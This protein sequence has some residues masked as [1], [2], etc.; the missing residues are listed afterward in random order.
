MIV[1]GRREWVNL[2]DLDLDNE[3]F[4]EIAGNVRVRRAAQAT[5]LLMPQ[6]ALVDYAV[7][8]MEENHRESS[9]IGK[10]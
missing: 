5:A 2:Q 9:S 8:W 1:N 4:A 3:D 6:R 7:R 10:E